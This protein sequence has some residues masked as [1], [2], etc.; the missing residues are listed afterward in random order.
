MR[1]VPLTERRGVNGDDGILDESLGPHQLV[2]AGVVD[3][4]D[5]TRLA[6]DRFRTPREVSSVQSAKVQADNS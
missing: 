4:V 1:L 5:D 2:I 3:G 6:G